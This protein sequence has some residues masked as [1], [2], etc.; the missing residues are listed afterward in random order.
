M[1]TSGPVSLHR[2]GRTATALSKLRLY[3]V[4]DIG[5]ASLAP[6]CCRRP[7]L[8][9]QHR[10]WFDVDV[11]HHHIQLPGFRSDGWIEAYQ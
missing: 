10:T 6:T 9:L 3:R 4:D 8:V 1:V 5:R 7:P 11:T 2:P